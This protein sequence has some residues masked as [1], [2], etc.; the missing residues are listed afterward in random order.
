[1][2]IKYFSSIKT[3][4]TFYVIMYVFSKCVLIR[5]YKAVTASWHRSKKTSLLCVWRGELFYKNFMLMLWFYAQ[6]KHHDVNILFFLCCTHG[7]EQTEYT[8]VLKTAICLWYHCVPK[9]IWIWHMSLTNLPCLRKCAY[10]H[11][12]LLFVIKWWLHTVTEY[13][14]K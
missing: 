6:L 9:P 10:W 12:K 8:Y 4:T 2:F 11:C 14:W 1:M 13:T 5:T 7:C 3:C